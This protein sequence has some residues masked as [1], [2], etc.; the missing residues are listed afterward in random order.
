MPSLRS[1][2]SLAGVLGDPHRSDDG[3]FD[4]VSSF[5]AIWDAIKK[6]FCRPHYHWCSKGWVRMVPPN[7]TKI[8]TY[9]LAISINLSQKW[10]F[11]RDVATTCLGFCIQIL[12]FQN[13]AARANG[14]GFSLYTWWNNDVVPLYF[15]LCNKNLI[16][17][18]PMQHR[19]L[20][21]HIQQRGAP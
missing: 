8:D 20:S 18:F 3:G 5:S 11:T 1:R 13:V 7:T 12:P 16:G 14:F 17:H 4:W 15:L 6:S 19:S 10:Y 2:L 21:N 9:R